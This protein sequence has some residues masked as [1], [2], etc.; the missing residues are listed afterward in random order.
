MA[1]EKATNITTLSNEDWSRA[2][3][4]GGGKVF[5]AIPGIDGKDRKID[6][7]RVISSSL[8]ESI[9]FRV[10]GTWQN[11]H[12]GLSGR[13]I[14]LLELAKGEYIIS[15]SVRSG[16]SIDKL[17][18][19][20]NYGHS[21]ICG[22]NGGKVYEEPQ[23]KN[24]KMLLNI[25]GRVGG[26]MDQIQ[27]LWSDP[28]KIP[29][30]LRWGSEYGINKGIEF[31]GLETNGINTK[32]TGVKIY[33]EKT[34][35]A[36]QFQVNSTWRDKQGI[37][38]GTEKSLI[39]DA[40]EYINKIHI[41]AGESSIEYIK[42]STNKQRHIEIGFYTEEEK[43]VN[44]EGHQ[45][46]LIDCKGIFDDKNGITQLQFRWADDEAFKHVEIEY[47]KPWTEQ[48]LRN[49]FRLKLNGATDEEIAKE[50]N[51]LQ[52]DVSA[53]FDKIERFCASKN[54]VIPENRINSYSMLRLMRMQENQDKKK[55]EYY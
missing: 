43:E 51:H 33:G 27:F 37:N 7:I 55:K 23:P 9:Q 41:K 42:L 40:K 20:T 11:G 13:N 5:D 48:E 46:A 52:F 6:A 2:Y 18:F 17:T 28:I 15:V 29:L 14:H 1:E 16:N 39:L 21:I 36:I 53:A 4:G 12:G 44:S 50:C 24:D 32:I 35:N 19:E 31:K 34:V 26:H 38:E 25:R 8:I 10:N 3:G 45:Q 30:N 49:G 22:G 54:L 47:N